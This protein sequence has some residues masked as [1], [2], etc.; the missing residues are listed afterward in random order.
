MDNIEIKRKYRQSFIKGVTSVFF[1]SVIQIEPLE[2]PSTSYAQNI[3]GY[4]KNVGSY[5]AK[6][7]GSTI[8]M[9]T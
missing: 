4:W 9:R 2:M 7:Y 6:A 3:A 5:M 8:L 1:P